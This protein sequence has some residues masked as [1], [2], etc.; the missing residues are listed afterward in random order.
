MFSSNDNRKYLLDLISP[1]SSKGSLPRA[2]KRRR[3][4][5]EM[6]KDTGFYT[7]DDWIM[8]GDEWRKAILYSEDSLNTSVI[9]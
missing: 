2:E 4:H 5:I 9:K 8:I 1:D 6:G 7:W 3:P